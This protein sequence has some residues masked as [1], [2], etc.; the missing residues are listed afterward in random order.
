[1]S[2]RLEGSVSVSCSARDFYSGVAVWLE[3][4]NVVNKRLLGAVT[5]FQTD[6]LKLVHLADAKVKEVGVTTPGCTKGG[7]VDRRET[8]SVVYKQPEN[9]QID[10]IVLSE[11]LQ[12]SRL[13]TEES[14]TGAPFNGK[15]LIREL[16][17][18]MRNMPQSLEAVIISKITVW[19]M[20]ISA[21]LN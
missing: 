14:V 9:K 2:W 19:L 3:R 8:D 6:Y 10:S 7:T 13:V 21:L 4:P 12:V 11:L 5:H 18:K 15:C 20:G 1:M 16:L 17:P